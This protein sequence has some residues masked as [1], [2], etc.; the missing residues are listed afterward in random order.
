MSLENGRR[1]RYTFCVGLSAKL[2][3]FFCF[4][5]E[6]QLFQK[7]LAR[8]NLAK[9]LKNAKKRQFFLSKRK[10]CLFSTHTY[11]EH[12]PL[13]YSGSAGSRNA[14]QARI[15]T[16]A[17]ACGCSE[18]T[19]RRTLHELQA[20]GFI[21]IKGNVQMLKNGS[22]RQTCNRYYLLDRSEWQPPQ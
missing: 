14:C 11:A 2:C 15:R 5:L 3:G 6:I 8:Q 17:N 1:K 18:S 9:T 4:S 13:P 19:A 21:D 7:T 12:F 16:I 10:N 20:I 22:H